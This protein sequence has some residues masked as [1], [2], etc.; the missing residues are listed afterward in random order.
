MRN[1]L[2]LAFLCLLGRTVCPIPS[3]ADAPYAAT[4]R[5]TDQAVNTV[6]PEMFGD[7]LEWVDSCKLWRTDLNGFD[8]E[9]VQSIKDAGV[10][11]IRYPGGTLSDYFHWQDAVGNDRKEEPNPFNKGVPQYPYFGPEELKQLTDRLG[12]PAFITLNAGTGTPDEAASWVTYCRD[13]GQKVTGFEV[14]NEVYMDNPDIPGVVVNKSP[15][16]YIAFFLATRRRIDALAPGTKLGAVGVL[17]TGPFPLCRDPKWLEKIVA[18]IGG[19]M[20]FI[21]IHDSYAPGLRTIGLSSDDRLSDEE[22][23]RTF[24]SAP[25]AVRDNIEQTKAVIARSAP[26]AAAHIA[27]EITE[28]GPLVL[29][30]TG[31]LESQIADMRWNRTLTA[32][33][34]LAGFYNM[35]LD[36]PRVTSVDH[37]PLLQDVFAALVGVRGAGEQRQIWHNAEFY[38]F[39]EYSGFVGRTVLRTDVA[40]PTYAAQLTGVTPNDDAVPCLD[41]DSFRTPDRHEIAIT[42]LN[43]DIDRICHVTIRPGPDNFR[44]ERVSL[45]SGPALDSTNEPGQPESVHPF[46]KEIDKDVAGGKL[47]LD[48]PPHSLMTVTIGL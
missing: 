38:I 37:L 28:A 35:V 6:R 36:E 42:L 18:G 7:N 3:M 27:I 31:K 26:E 46:S 23:A 17:D 1:G 4:V 30:P 33:L 40:S 14:G 8:P 12:I 20:D 45:I 13:H 44:V 21:A 32:A 41:A 48:I 47:E 15:E 43:R 2:L 34:Y 29:A 39:Q 24:M 5:V 10:T 25:L 16:E 22:Y 11:Q 9:M 19:K